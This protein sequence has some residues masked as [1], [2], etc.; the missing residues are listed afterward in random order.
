MAVQV[1]RC[2]HK[3]KFHVIQVDHM[4]EGHVIR[5]ELETRAAHATQAGDKMVGVMEV[6]YMQVVQVF[7]VC[8]M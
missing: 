3:M 2:L 7:Q 1:N 6:D 5:A 4:M 8:D